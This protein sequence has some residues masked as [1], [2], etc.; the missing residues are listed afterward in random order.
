MNNFK[1]IA[2]DALAKIKCF[3]LVG[4]DWTCAAS[5]GIQ[6]CKN[7]EFRDYAKMYCRRCGHVS[8]LS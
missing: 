7:Q 5:E 8:R 6:P 1:N 4:H 2:K 3:L